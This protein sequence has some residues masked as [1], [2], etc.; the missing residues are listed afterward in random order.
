MVRLGR[1]G[2][3]GGGGLGHGLQVIGARGHERRLGVD[4]A[5]EGDSR[6]HITGRPAPPLQILVLGE[7]TLPVR[8]DHLLCGARGGVRV[9]VVLIIMMEVMID[10]MMG[11]MTMITR[12][13][14]L[15]I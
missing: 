9:V 5:G 7:L 6:A 15:P 4:G 12:F 13:T 11:V 3:D 2:G 10:V 8:R 14:T 1:D